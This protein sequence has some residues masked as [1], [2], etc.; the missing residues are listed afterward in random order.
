MARVRCVIFDLG[1]V[2]WT[3]VRGALEA[4]ERSRA[5]EPHTVAAV[6]RHLVSDHNGHW[7]QFERGQIDAAAFSEAFEGAAQKVHG[8]PIGVR[9]F[10]L[11]EVFNSTFEPRAEMLAAIASLRRRGLTVAALTNNWDT[12]EMAKAVNRLRPHFD[13]MFESWRLRVRKPEP[14]IFSHVMQQLKV[15]F[16]P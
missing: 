10:E 14:A 7:A 4:F 1:G 6:V 3:D 16:R 13:T 9:G 12:P 2:V 11:L 5:L 8:R 15:C